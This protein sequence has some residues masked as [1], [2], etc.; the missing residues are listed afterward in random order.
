MIELFGHRPTWAEIDL[1]NLTFNFHSIKRYVG[2]T[3]EYMAVVKADAYGHGAVECSRRLESEGV[4]W[5]AVATVEEGLELREA[6]IRKPILILGGFWPGQE[7][8]VLDRNLTPVVFRIDQAKTIGE[9]ASD[10]N[11]KVK[12]HIKFD[13]GMGRVGF[14]T[15]HAGELAEEFSKIDGIEV[16][17]LMT[18]FAAADMPSENA[19]TNHQ[20][21]KFGEAVVA[22]H[23]HGFRPK[24]LDMANSPGAVV[25]PVSRSKLVRIG[26]LLYG[27][28]DV[29]PQE[30]ERPELLPVLSLRSKIA[31]VKNVP[32]GETIGYGRTF[33]TVRDSLIATIPIGYHDGLSRSLSNRGRVLI[34]GEFAPIVGRVSMDWTIIDVTD[35]PA[36]T[37][38]VV[39]IIGTDHSNKIG[40]DDIARLSGTIAYEITCGIDRRVNRIYT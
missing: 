18:H 11:T 13:T 7:S 20:I 21:A 40:A 38:D 24:Y 17:G 28:G 34:N 10:K 19:F 4:D 12:I 3:I 36:K 26:G 31:L 8:A 9:A 29:L 25:H 5:F 37:G 2:E 1:N 15:D 23:A 16:E 35:I 14:D 6:G 30:A 39:T 22:F 32:Y 27:L 33:S